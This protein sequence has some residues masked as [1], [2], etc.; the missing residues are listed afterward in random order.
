LKPVQI[1]P[2]TI[3]L[4]LAAS[5]LSTQNS[6]VREKTGSMSRLICLSEA[7]CIPTN[8]VFRLG[9]LWRLGLKYP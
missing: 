9:G 8:C 4:V 1:I 5:P 6:D 3:K 7:T 2:K